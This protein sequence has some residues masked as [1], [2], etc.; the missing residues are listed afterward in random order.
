MVEEWIDVKGYEGRYKVSNLGNLMTFYRGKWLNKSIQID[1]HTGYPCA[2]LYMYNIRKR[3]NIHRLVAEAF[4]NNPEEKEEVDHINGIRTDNRVDNLRWATRKENRNNPITL[5]RLRIAFTGHNSPH[6][7]KKRS[8]ETCKKLSKALKES[9]KN[10][11]MTGALCKHSKPIY[12]Y[13][14]K[15]NYINSFVGQAEAS[16]ITGVNQGDICRVSLGL[17]NSAGGYI[18]KSFKVDNLNNTNL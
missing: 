16:R 13:D 14:I 15:G 1:K 4:L 17:R 9:L 18:W 10:K 3:K 8:E 6:Y 5:E 7:G 2:T 11:N 12:Q